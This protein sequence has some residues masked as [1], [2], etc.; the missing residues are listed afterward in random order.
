MIE[1]INLNLIPSGVSPV[2][3][4]SQ[5]DEGRQIKINLFEGIIPYTIQSGD[6]FTLNV[7]KPDNTIVTTSVS[8]TQGDNH[9]TIS[10]T[11]QIAAVVGENL[12]ELKITNGSTV[13][14]TL[15][16]IMQVERDVLADG[17]PSQ[18][19]IE[20]LDERIAEA[21]GDNYY[22]KTETDALLA[23][24]ADKSEFYN[25]YPTEQESG[26]I[27][28]FTDGAD[29]IP[30]KSLFSQIVAVQSGSGTPSP[31]N[32]RAISGFDNG[33]ITRC[34]KNLFSYDLP[35]R[36]GYWTDNAFVG[37]NA[38][39]PKENAVTWQYIRVYVEGLSSVTLSGFDNQDGTNCAWLSSENVNDVISRFNSLSKN[40]TK[41]VPSGAKY[42]CLTIYNI[43]DKQTTYSNAQL[44]IGDTASEFEQYNGNTY[45]FTFGQTVYGAK[46]NVT[47]GELNI[48]EE[49]KIF[50]GNENW[51]KTS[52]G[53][54]FYYL[55]LTTATFPYSKTNRSK[56]ICD[57][58][59]F[60]GFT[61][62]N[63]SSFLADK[64]YLLYDYPDSST[65]REIAFRNDDITTLEDWK[66]ALA[67]S[68]IEIVFVL[69][70]PIT[71]QLTPTE[72]KTLLGENNFY[73]NTGDVDVTIRA[74]IGLYIDK[75]LNAN[76]STPNNL[77]RAAAYVDDPESVNETQEDNVEPQNEER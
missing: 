2:C 68:A 56:N 23:L 55:P 34:G 53:Y 40:G 77:S 57:K 37:T 64:E 24:K 49:H 14:G 44:E 60:K 3:H 21:I 48:T 63:Y 76:R 52:T 46:L 8:G 36:N 11:E 66:A 74:D 54:N 33:V 29:N 62:G 73:S 18:S 67:N 1:S 69:A 38:I 25:V 75:R 16:F 59:A 30:V 39:V 15:N 22:N 47:T 9:I 20:D 31:S 72:V 70:T 17:I 28:H 42:L 32:P 27:A 43:K 50:N 13:I 58:Y 7:R 10:T 41:T 12:C 61:S 45:T 26:A 35:I 5:Y 4:V 65:I 6:A 19:V 71:V 51:V